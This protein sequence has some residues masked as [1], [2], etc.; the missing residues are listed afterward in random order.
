MAHRALATPDEVA[1]YL[2]KPVAT[3]TQWRYLGKG[4]RYTMIGRTVRYRWDDVETWIDE[5]YV[6]KVAG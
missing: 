3:L 4:P 1:A 2:G 5:Q 6:E